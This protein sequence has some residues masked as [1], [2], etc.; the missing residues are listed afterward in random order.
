MQQS[1]RLRNV[2][3]GNCLT[4]TGSPVPGL[5]VFQSGCTF[6]SPQQRWELQP[7]FGGFYTVRSATGNRCLGVNSLFNNTPVRSEMCNF[8]APD[9]Q[10]SFTNTFTGQQVRN[11]LTNRCLTAQGFGPFAPVVQSNCSFVFPLAQRW[12]L[13]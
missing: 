4:R 2:L 3:T 12:R 10:W 1:V 13:V 7:R 6:F 11:R 5:P 9:Q 8:F